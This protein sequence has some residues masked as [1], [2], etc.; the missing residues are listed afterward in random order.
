MASQCSSRADDSCRAVSSER[1]AATARPWAPYLRATSINVLARRAQ[2]GGAIFLGL[3]AEL[4]A[5]LV[6]FQQGLLHDVR[7]AEPAPE[8]PIQLKPPDQD[9]KEIA[10]A[11]RLPPGELL[12][13]VKNTRCL[14]RERVSREHRIACPVMRLRLSRSFREFR[15]SHRPACRQA[16][17]KVA[18]NQTA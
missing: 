4:V 1:S 6:R 12:A 7:C 17:Q 9:M 10:V 11:L 2:P 8:P 14:A 15:T 16:C 13:H 5:L 18:K 3:P